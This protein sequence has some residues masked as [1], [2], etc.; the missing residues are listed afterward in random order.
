[1]VAGAGLGERGE[2]LVPRELAAI[3][4]DAADGGAVAAQELGGGVEHD[5]G[6]VL[7][8]TA[9]IGRRHGVV[10][11]QRHAGFMRDGRHL[12]DI[13]HVHARVGDGLA[14]E[15]AR[16]RGDGLAEVLGIA[17]LDE[18]DIDAQAAEA[19]VELRVSAAVERAGGHQLV[20]LP[21]QAGDGQELRRLAA[22]RSQ[23]A[24]AAF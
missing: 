2:L 5:I 14:V 21:H 17:G 18:L 1:M 4:D 12:L 15:R 20:A 19:H 11:H 24:D 6:A 8:G 9:Q 3:D 22:G 10:D 7:D 13:E 23:A 16:L